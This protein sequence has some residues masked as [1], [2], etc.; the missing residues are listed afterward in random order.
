MFLGYTVLKS[1]KKVNTTNKSKFKYVLVFVLKLVNFLNSVK[2]SRNKVVIRPS[3]S[4]ASMSMSITESSPLDTGIHGTQDI[5]LNP[6]P[7]HA[8]LQNQSLDTPQMG[9]NNCQSSQAIND[10]N[11]ERKSYQNVVVKNVS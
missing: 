9:S 8:A 10:Q 1:A 11:F 5:S 4:V 7:A 6:K 2:E 3:H